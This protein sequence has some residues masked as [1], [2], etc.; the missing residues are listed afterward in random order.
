[1]SSS[2]WFGAV[3]VAALRHA[4]ATDE[5]RRRPAPTLVEMNVDIS[6]C[7]REE[8]REIEQAVRKIWEQP[9]PQ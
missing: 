6:Q 9:K 2:A 8:I 4:T 5:Q 1:M 3:N 7:T